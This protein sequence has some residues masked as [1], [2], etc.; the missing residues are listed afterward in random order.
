MYICVPSCTYSW[1]LTLVIGFASHADTEELKHYSN[2]GSYKVLQREKLS[3]TK[4]PF[5]P[6]AIFLLQIMP[7]PALLIYPWIFPLLKNAKVIVLY[8]HPKILKC[9]L[10]LPIS[11][12]V[13]WAYRLH[14]QLKFLPKWTKSGA[15][16][17]CGRQVILWPNSY[18]KS[19]VWICLCGWITACVPVW[20]EK[21][22]IITY[23]I[24]PKVLGH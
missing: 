3:K 23:F 2:L 18:F 5:G 6:E 22:Q 14:V 17:S 24:E 19:A 9:D 10:Q 4:L 7:H 8:F 12:F 16:A 20:M 13:S 11:I 1:V 15:V 21:Y